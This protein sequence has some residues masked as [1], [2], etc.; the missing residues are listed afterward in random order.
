MCAS[1]LRHFP[2]RIRV[3]PSSLITYGVSSHS[4]DT[5]TTIPLTVKTIHTSIWY[6]LAVLRAGQSPLRSPD[7]PDCLHS[8]YSQPRKRHFLSPLFSI[9]CALFCRSVFDNSFTIIL[10]RT[11]CKKHRGWVY[12]SGF[13]SCF[14]ALTNSCRGC[15]EHPSRGDRYMR[16]ASR[17]N[18]L[19][20][21]RCLC[22]NPTG[23][24]AGP[25]RRG[26]RSGGSP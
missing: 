17:P 4:N 9:S 5:F 14:Q 21:P 2:E 22:G 26:W 11:L 1:F 18:F 24:S 10:F 19:S 25:Y 13:A 20:V 8:S 12:P 7:R 16:G 6:G 3:N 23:G 15:P